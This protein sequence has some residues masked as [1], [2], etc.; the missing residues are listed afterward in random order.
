ME[1]DLNRPEFQ[2]G[3]LKLEKAE[4]LAFFETLRKLKQLSWSQ[5]HR[6]K[7]LRWRAFNLSVKTL[8]GCA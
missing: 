8:I 2:A 7:G 6:D 5:V 1:F 4:L 3:L